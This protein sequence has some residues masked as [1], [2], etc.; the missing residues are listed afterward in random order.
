[1]LSFI[2]YLMM[3]GGGNTEWSRTD[4]TSH[5]TITTGFT[6]TGLF[7]PGAVRANSSRTAGKLYFETRI[8]STTGGNTRLIGIADSTYSLTTGTL[9]EVDSHSAG[10]NAADGSFVWESATAGHTTG[11]SGSPSGNDYV[12]IAVDIPNKLIW[13]HVNGSYIIGN[14][15]LGTFGFDYVVSGPVFPIVGHT[16]NST[17]FVGNFAEPFHYSIPSGFQAWD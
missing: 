5:F 14:P 11:G 12:G 2:D 4:K 15:A 16:G 3:G 10:I 7:G 17:V 8:S 1:M 6:A 13:G 9:G